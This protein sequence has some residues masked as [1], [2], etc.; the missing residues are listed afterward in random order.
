MKIKIMIEN[1]TRRWPS[2]QA[3][4]DTSTS[5]LRQ[6][7]KS[8]LAFRDPLGSAYLCGCNLLDN[9]CRIEND[10]TRRKQRTADMSPRQYSEVFRM[11]AERS[12]RLCLIP[13]RAK[14]D[15]SL[16]AEITL[17]DIFPAHCEAVRVPP[18]KNFIRPGWG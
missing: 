10:A 8:P 3:R 17:Q 14:K 16:R 12:S 4:Q 7:A 13:L 9:D 6:R 15:P 2:P 11:R 1:G 18:H 5:A